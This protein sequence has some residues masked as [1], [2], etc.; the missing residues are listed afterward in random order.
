MTDEPTVAAPAAAPDLLQSAAEAIDKAETAETTRAS[1][2]EAA[3]ADWL[4]TEIR[5]SPIARATE[6]WNHLV[7]ALPRLTSK[8]KEI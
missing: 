4:N 3:V 2:I 5:N 6:A 1:A 8:L 7:S